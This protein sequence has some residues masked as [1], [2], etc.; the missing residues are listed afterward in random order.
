MPFQ[1]DEQ[2]LLETD[3]S[4]EIDNKYRKVSLQNIKTSGRIDARSAKD[5]SLPQLQSS[6]YIDARSAKDV[7]L[8]QL[9]SSCDIY[10]GSA[11]TVSLPQLKSSHD[12]DARNAK[13]VSLPQLQSSHNIYAGSAETVSLPQLQS[14]GTIDVGPQ[15]AGKQTDD[16]LFSPVIGSREA[17]SL[18]FKNY[19]LFKIGCRSQMDMQKAIEIVD[20]VYPDGAYHDEYHAFFKQCQDV[21]GMAP[22]QEGGSTVSMHKPSGT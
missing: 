21:M 12:I 3:A 13:D 11:E 14:S 4:I 6:R 2:G 5:V 10:A 9:Q 8:P 22:K 17:V 15:M 19:N 7:S 18:F 20:Q 1:F 16:I